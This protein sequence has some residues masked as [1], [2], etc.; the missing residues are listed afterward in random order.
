MPIE[1][2]EGNT[3][4]EFKEGLIRGEKQGIKVFGVIK[5]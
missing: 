3:A 5:S 1:V 2:R 4:L